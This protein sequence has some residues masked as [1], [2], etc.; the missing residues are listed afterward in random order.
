M[1]LN[2]IGGFKRIQ[3]VWGDENKRTL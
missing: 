1:I 3:K 2:L